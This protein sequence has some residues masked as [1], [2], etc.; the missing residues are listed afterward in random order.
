MEDNGGGVNRNSYTNYYYPYSY[1]NIVNSFQT[2]KGYIPRF[3][4]CKKHGFGLKTCFSNG[5][6]QYVSKISIF[7]YYDNPIENYNVSIGDKKLSLS[8]SDKVAFACF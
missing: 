4:R 3:T 8:A 7:L 6:I 2:R 1:S 5:G